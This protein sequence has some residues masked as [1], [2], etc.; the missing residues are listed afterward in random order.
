M[1]L[2]V[3]ETDAPALV[4]RTVQP[5]GAIFP[6]TH[7][8]Q[9]YSSIVS[10]VGESNTRETVLSGL[11]AT[12]AKVEALPAGEILIVGSRCSRFKDGSHELNANVYGVDGAHRRSFLLGDGIEHAQC[13]SSGNIWVGYFDEGVFGNFGWNLE[14]GILGAAGLSRFS[15]DGMKI[16]DFEPPDGFDSITDC[17]ALNVTQDAVW[18][19][20]YTDFPIVRIDSDYKIRAWSNEISGARTFAVDGERVLLFGGYGD[21]RTSCVLLD[22]N[23]DR[24][25]LVAEVSLVIPET[26]DLSQATVRGKGKELHVFSGDDWFRFSLD[27]ID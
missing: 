11:T 3:P 5:G 23:N 4:A 24:A 8:D 16:W 9:D 1:R 22:L 25:D 15:A 6:K 17:Y 18:A 14:S 19:C 26:V 27:S 2:L 13:D 21:R 7:T 10:I 20:Y 12:F